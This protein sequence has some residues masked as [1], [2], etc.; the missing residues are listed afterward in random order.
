MFKKRLFKVKLEQTRLF[1]YSELTEIRSALRRE[2]MIPADR[3]AVINVPLRPGTYKYK[4]IVYFINP[5]RDYH[6]CIW[7]KV[8]YDEV[9]ATKQLYNFFGKN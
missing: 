6:I 1:N 9:N 8:P 7:T 3:I 2:R 4:T 5:D